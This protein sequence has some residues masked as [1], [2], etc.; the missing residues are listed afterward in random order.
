MIKNNVNNNNKKI[1]NTI[2][3][4]NSNV[5]KGQRKEKKSKDDL[6]EIKPD[7]I[8]ITKTIQNQVKY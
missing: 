1:N 6:N 8:V 5:T 4:N 7:L 3:I 2:F